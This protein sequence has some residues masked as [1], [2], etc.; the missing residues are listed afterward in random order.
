VNR[1]ALGAAVE[2]FVVEVA[3]SAA[4]IVGL[5]YL[6]KRL[7]RSGRTLDP[8]FLAW[9]GLG[10]LVAAVMVLTYLLAVVS[11]LAAVPAVLGL[12]SSVALLPGGRLYTYSAVLLSVALTAIALRYLYYYY[13]WLRSRDSF[14]KPPPMDVSALS[15]RRIP[16]IKVQ[17]TTKG[18]A[19]P[20]VQRG[21]RE[22]EQ[23]LTRHPWL[24]PSLTAEVITEEATEVVELRREF[25]S[26]RLRVD[27]VLLPADYETPRGT[28]LKARALHY[29]VERRLAGP[30]VARGE[31]YIVHFDEETVVT[32]AHLLILVDYLSRDP[33][34]VSQG[35]ILYP[36]EWEETPWICKALESMRPF[37]C[38][39]CARVMEHP[40][41]PH[42]HGSNLVVDEAAENEIGWDFG[43]LE[44][45]PYI[46]ED[47]LFGLRAYAVLG[48]GGFGWH[49]ATMLEQP[50]FSLHWAVQQRMRWVLGALQ[51]LAA[52]RTRPE[53]SNISGWHKRRLQ[54]A[55][56]FRIA[57]YSLGFPLGFAGVYFFLRPAHNAVSQTAPLG[58]WRLLIIVSGV[59][60]LASYQ[61]GL[62][63]NL[64]YKQMAWSDRLKHHAVILVLTPVTG[65][66]ETAGPFIAVLRW[67]LGARRASWTPTPKLADR[68]EPDGVSLEQAEASAVPVLEPVTVPSGSRA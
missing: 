53:Y 51:G 2:L 15:A 50:P 49:G 67:L 26:S 34:P 54:L 52:M 3:L 61:I 4:V 36:L 16:R 56:N 7:A 32:D 37:G 12:N 30:P 13:C 43:T 20:V 23:S 29:L 9:R 6:R 48:E 62:A 39:E 14:R 40:P 19:L 46:A 18:G 11:T 68:A 66:C 31:C 65:L 44:G 28:K 8:R 33:K 38:S 64:R 5:A 47:L 21:L 17:I 41:P 1:L 45:Q 27:A 58:L 35:P 24:E 59:L 25:K 10:I 55:I 42:L 22:L 60:W 57:T 63:R